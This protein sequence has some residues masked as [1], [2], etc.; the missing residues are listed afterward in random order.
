M[1]SLFVIPPSVNFILYSA[2]LCLVLKRKGILGGCVGLH[3]QL[4][5]W[6]CRSLEMIGHGMMP[7]SQLCID[8]AHKNGI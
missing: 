2:C 1:V 3:K 8:T 4:V 5:N 7:R 6:T